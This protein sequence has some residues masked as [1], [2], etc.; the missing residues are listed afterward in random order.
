[1]TNKQLIEIITDANNLAT[2]YF[3]ESFKDNAD[4]ILNQEDEYSETFAL[5]LTTFNAVQL[6]IYFTLYQVLSIEE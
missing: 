5:S 6:L 1:M 4:F 3:I 2:V